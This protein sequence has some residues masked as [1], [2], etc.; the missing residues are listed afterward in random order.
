MKKKVVLISLIIFIFISLIIGGFIFYNNKNS[1]EVYVWRARY[2]W[3]DEGELK[4]VE[5]SKEIKEGIVNR[6]NANTWACFRKEFTIDNKRDIK[7]VLARIVVDSKYWL[8]INNELVIREG[9]LKR[10]QTVDSTYYDEVDITKYLTEGENVISIMVWYYGRTGFSH[11]DS[12]HGA[13]LFETKIGDEYLIT[14]ET[15]K[16]IK[17]PVFLKD[18]VVS[19]TRLSESGIYYDARNELKDWYKKEYDDSKW[20]DATV[21]GGAGDFPWWALYERSIPEFWY[22]DIIEYENFEKEK[23][24][25]KLEENTLIKLDLPY[26]IQFIPYL[27]VEAEEGKEI[28]ISTDENYLEKGKPF[29]VRYIT[30]KGIQSFESYSWING[31]HI[32]YFIPKGVKIINLGYRPTGYNSEKIGSFKSDD[33]FYNTLWDMAAKT[34]YVNMR[35]TY[36]DCPDRE[37]ALWWGDNTLS[38]TQAMYVF[39]DNAYDL[40]EKSLDMLIGWK[41]E[42]VLLTV[43]PPK[44]TEMHIPVQMLLGIPSMYDYYMYT[45]RIEILEKVYPYVIDYLNLWKLSD[46]DGL[47]K[48]TDFYALWPWGDSA[49]EIDYTALENMCY[50]YALTS[51]YDMANVLE[52]EE[53]KIKLKEKKDLIKESMKKALWKNDGY[54]T[55]QEGKNDP[56]ANVVA[57]LS[58][59]ADESK[60]SKIYDIIKNEK[61]NSP[62]M[63]YYLQCSMVKMNKIDEVENRIK[64][65]YSEM[66][67]N[68]D[69]YSTL[70]E[71]WDINFGSKN[72]AWAGGPL[73]IMSRD[74]A[75]IKPLKPGYEE[76]LIKPQTI[77]LNKISTKTFTPKGNISLEFERK[78]DVLNIKCNVPTKTLIAIEK[79]SENPTIEMNSKLVYEN[80]DF[81]NRIGIKYHSE[82]ER[83]I[84]FYI[85]KGEYDIVSK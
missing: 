80:K 68:K 67:K 59:M 53:D 60:Y 64:D 42:N 13:L 75:G 62:F 1:N 84:Y 32:C 8:Y 40:Y 82:D 28:I 4:P 39:D 29:K 72:H 50:Y 73:V 56:K 30:K 46:E 71:Y 44:R 70:W 76:I 61:E 18:D 77:N 24:K 41:H 58:G 5:D 11:V 22:G 63:E 55:A 36:M 52:Y 25:E 34:L 19:N 48:L 74:L 81:K 17:N 7:D 83:F 49:G 2:I 31:E 6:D 35:D 16:C 37:R 9:G 10:G 3:F 12:T 66:V 14:D 21:Y 47:M 15:W 20:E 57:V 54:R 38:M 27:E 79:L 26:N 85:N 78:E 51:V 65:R 69:T 33:E 45:G 23:Y 43:I